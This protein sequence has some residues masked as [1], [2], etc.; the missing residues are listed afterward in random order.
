MISESGHF[1]KSYCNEGVNFTV[2][3]DKS[4]YLHYCERVFQ[5]KNLDRGTDERK[6]T[7][8]KRP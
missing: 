7:C 2:G 8:K 1:C 6:Y 4:K 3:L 5:T